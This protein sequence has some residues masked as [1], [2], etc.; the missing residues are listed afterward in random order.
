MYFNAKFGFSR[1]KKNTYGACG[2]TVFEKEISA[3][4]SHQVL[5]VG[6]AALHEIET[7]SDI[8]GQ[9]WFA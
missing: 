8:L 4:E 6:V 9:L 3:R 2:K 1:I 7:N 5:G